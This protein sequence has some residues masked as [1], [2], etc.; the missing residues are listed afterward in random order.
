MESTTHSRPLTPPAAPPRPLSLSGANT[1]SDT[2][3]LQPTRGEL[4]VRS[5]AAGKGTGSAGGSSSGSGSELRAEAG[6]GWS[7]L[8]LL[9]TMEEGDVEGGGLASR[10]AGR[11]SREGGGPREAGGGWLAGGAGGMPR[12]AE[13]GAMHRDSARNAVVKGGGI[14]VASSAVAALPGPPTCVMRDGA[15][16]PFPPPPPPPP[17]ESAGARADA[18]E[19]KSER[20]PGLTRS[21]SQ[22]GLQPREGQR[23]GEGGV[24]GRREGRGAGSSGAAVAG[25]AAEA[26]WGAALRRKT[27]GRQGSGSSSGSSIGAVRIRHARGKSFHFSNGQAPALQASD[28]SAGGGRRQQQ[29]HIRVFAAAPSSSLLQ[30]SQPLAPLFPSQ[31]SRPPSHTS[32]GLYVNVPSLPPPSH[33]HPLSS[34][35]SNVSSLIASSSN[36]KQFRR[37]ASQRVPGAGAAGAWTAGSALQAAAEA[38]AVA[39]ASGGGDRGGAGGVKQKE[40]ARQNQWQWEALVE[41]P[42]QQRQ[43]QQPVEEQARVLQQLQLQRRIASQFY[44]FPPPPWQAPWGSEPR[45]Q[46]ARGATGGRGAGAATGGHEGQ[47]QQQGAPQ[48]QQRVR[49]P[50]LHSQRSNPELLARHLAAIEAGSQLAGRQAAERADRQVLGSVPEGGRRGGRRRKSE[51]VGGEGGRIVG[52]G[53]AQPNLLPIAS[54][55]DFLP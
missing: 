39:R 38:A 10:E 46:E 16:D 37:S 19:R 3:S 21:S 11:G 49:V 51:Q 8:R 42:Q 26:Q 45:V 41:Q 50:L 54:K 25:V 30:C 31:I 35:L 9:S 43:Q 40:G 14:S 15:A 44:Q 12:E 4:A 1:A 33:L 22:P 24:D 48:Q 47:R 17:G 7:S 13:G 6:I 55:V 18:R 52:M 32:S 20:V 5:A 23:E 28:P 53:V 27:A 34:S 2:P 36:T 29:Q